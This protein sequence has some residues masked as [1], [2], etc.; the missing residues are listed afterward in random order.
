LIWEN[1]TCPETITFRRTTAT[2]WPNFSRYVAT[3]WALCWY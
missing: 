3:I 2:G 1:V